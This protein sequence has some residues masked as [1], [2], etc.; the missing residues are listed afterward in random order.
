MKN[1]GWDAFFWDRYRRRSIRAATCQ[2]VAVSSLR[3]SNS[4]SREKVITPLVTMAN[5]KERGY[6]RSEPEVSI[7]PAFLASACL[8]CYRLRYFCLYPF[9]RH[10]GHYRGCRYALFSWYIANLSLLIKPARRINRSA[11][12]RVF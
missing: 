9:F 10:V 11:L 3:S 5:T 4:L 7:I 8:R 6:R 1:E 12:T 2:F